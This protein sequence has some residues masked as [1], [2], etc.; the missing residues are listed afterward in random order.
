M[1]EITLGDVKLTDEEQR[2]IL[3]VWQ[4]NVLGICPDF[5]EAFSELRPVADH[6]AAADK[7]HRLIY[8]TNESPN[9]DMESGY[10]LTT[11]GDW[12]GETLFDS[13]GYEFGDLLGDV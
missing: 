6:L 9:S 13:G 3:I 2:C 4:A 5:E 1:A 10:C 12:V 7:T 11:L 8:K